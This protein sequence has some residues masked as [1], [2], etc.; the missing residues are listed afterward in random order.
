MWLLLGK[1]IFKGTTNR[2]GD[3]FASS[4]YFLKVSRIHLFCYSFQ[5]FDVQPSF[6]SLE[7]FQS[8]LKGDH[9]ITCIY[10]CTCFTPFLL[11]ELWRYWWDFIRGTFYLRYHL[12]FWL[13]LL[14]PKNLE[15]LF[16][17]SLVPT[18]SFVDCIDFDASWNLSNNLPA[19]D[20]VQPRVSSGG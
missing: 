6:T 15:G 5:V 1:L 11:V 3:L 20:L 19:A 8:V 12:L 4:I 2:N 10:F 17:F 14:C 7:V 16:L 13:L 18:M 9:L